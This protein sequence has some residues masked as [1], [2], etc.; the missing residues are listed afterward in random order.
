[1]FTMFY[2]PW[3]L[4]T[5][6]ASTGYY[7][8]SR[9]QHI[10]PILSAM[11]KMTSISVRQKAGLCNHCI[12][13]FGF[14]FLFATCLQA[15]SVIPGQSGPG[16]SEP[17]ILLFAPELSA[18]H[19]G[20]TATDADRSRTIFRS[21]S[22]FAGESFSTMKRK[23]LAEDPP[24]PMDAREAFA[25]A[26]AFM[27]DEDPGARPVNVYG[28]DSSLYDDFEYK[29]TADGNML[30]LTGESYFWEVAYLNDLDSLIHFALVV[31]SEI[32]EYDVTDMRDFPPQ[33]L[34]PIPLTE[35]KSIPE[36]FISSKS[37]LAAARSFGLDDYL[38]I[39]ELDGWFDVDYNLG[40]FFFEFPGILDSESPVFW[41]VLFDG[42]AWD[43]E[44]ERNVWVEANF[45]I[46]AL[47][48]N[49]LGKLVFSSEDELE[50]LDFMDIYGK[51]GNQM[52]DINQGAALIQ[53]FGR[54]ED[55]LP[56]MPVGKSSDWMAAWFDEDIEMVYF[57]LTRNGE[58]FSQNIFP[59]S[60]I[61]EEDRPPEGH[62][63]SIDLRF[64]S[65]HA[66]TTSMNAGL[67]QQLEQAPQ[68]AFARIDY[69]LHSGY[70]MFPDILDEDS[71]PF[72]HL[73]VH[74]ETFN[75]EW[76]RDFHEIH[77]HLVD[78][79]TGEYLGATTETSAEE[80]QEHELAAGMALHQN[81]PN[82]FNPETRI[83]WEMNAEQ[84]VT[85]SV[86]DLLGR[87]VAKL[88]DA[89][90]RAGMHSATFD[91]SMLSSGI[92]V[93][94]LEAGG[95]VLNRKMTVVK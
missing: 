77:N 2:L 30:V 49:L 20:S 12:F 45:L 61:P 1:M 64:G 26:R 67:Q 11:K 74:I 86:H 83:F 28:E 6:S 68:D 16:H 70:N 14:V 18:L 32:V 13:M 91:A 65:V 92:Y 89:T 93:Y 95:N 50:F 10:Q 80:E 38:Y 47:T 81:Y 27:A 9:V 40:G 51:L 35:L 52:V 56:D 36:N 22:P 87:R 55:L 46:D 17:D 69:N 31:G 72:W 29:L 43:D 15:Q 88:A 41:D 57:F 94:R 84:H 85:L 19:N 53:A 66:L 8:G 7:W 44:E 62:F 60:D 23:S 58:I 59:L 4:I 73:E 54:E 42:H 39:T 78:A 37:A 24:E 75:E 82:P 5:L 25:I 34:P 63:K 79:V 33:E 90:F 3:I 21:W 71:N 76:E 48:G